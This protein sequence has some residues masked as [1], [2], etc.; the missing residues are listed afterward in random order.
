MEFKLLQSTDVTGGTFSLT[1]IGM[2]VRPC[3][4]SSAPD[5]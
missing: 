4:F 1:L 5:G 3:S 2:L